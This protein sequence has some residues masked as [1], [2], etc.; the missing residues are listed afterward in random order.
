MIAVTAKKQEK[1]TNRCIRIYFSNSGDFLS[2]M[3]QSITTD[4]RF[5]KK[6]L[7]II[8]IRNMDFSMRYILNNN[9]KNCRQCADVI[10]K[11]SLQYYI[12]KIIPQHKIYTRQDI[13]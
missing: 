3:A 6:G 11:Q 7:K 1:S 5:R 13:V 9:K 4:A 2:E 8:K 10:Q 12:Q